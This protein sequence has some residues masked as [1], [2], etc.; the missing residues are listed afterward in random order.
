MI[1]STIGMHADPVAAQGK[2]A[3]ARAIEHFPRRDFQAGVKS[4]PELKARYVF[5]AGRFDLPHAGIFVALAQDEPAAIM[6]LV[7]AN[8][9]L[10]RLGSASTR[11]AFAGAPGFQKSAVQVAIAANQRTSK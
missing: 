4:A 3:L 11:W 5:A 7:A 10:A 6:S 2:G 1:A 9:R 8:A